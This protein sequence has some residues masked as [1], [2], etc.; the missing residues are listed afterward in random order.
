[1]NNL[2]RQRK[3]LEKKL[4]SKSCLYKYLKAVKWNQGIKFKAKDSG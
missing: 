2:K 3:S 4:E 1:M